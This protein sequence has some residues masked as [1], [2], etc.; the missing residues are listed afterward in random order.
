MRAYWASDEW[1][2][3]E[4]ENGNEGYWAYEDETARQSQAWDE[5]QEDYY[6]EYGYFQGKGKKGNKEEGKGKKGH[7]PQQD[8]GKGQ[9]DG[10][11]EANYVNPSHSSQSSTEQAAL[12]SLSDASGF[13]ATD[14]SMNLTSVKMIEGEDKQKGPESSGCA[15]LGQE[16]D[17]AMKVEE[18]GM[19]FHTENQMPPTV[20]ILDLGCACARAIG[21]RNAIN[22]FCEYVDKNDCGLWYKIEPTSS[23]LFFAN[24]QQT[25]CTEKLVIQVYD[26]A[27]NVQ[28]TEFD[29]VGEGNVPLLMSLPQMRNLGFQFELSPQQSFLNCARLGMWKYKLRMSKST[30]L[31]MDFQDIAWYMS[32]VYFKTP[33]VQSF[34]SEFGKFEYSQLSVETFAFAIDDDWE[35]DYHRKELIRHHKTYRSQLFKIEGSKYPI[36]LDDLES[37]RTTFIEMK[38]GTKKVEKDDWRAVSGPEKRLDKQWRGRTVFKI[39]NGVKLPE[40]LSTVKPSSKLHRISDPSDEVKPAYPPS[41]EKADDPKSSAASA[42]EG[43]SSG[44]GLTGPKRRLSQKTTAVAEDEAKQFANDLIRNST[45]QSRRNLKNQTSL[46]T[47]ARRVMM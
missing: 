2:G 17:S 19:A 7:G 36:P 39:K 15:L 18:E 33:E 11:G 27:W 24:S 25:K 10:K 37:T 4:T 44:S 1:Q 34:F 43:K 30:H 28:A 45:R 13:F 41:G 40:E 20:A 42:E 32:A 23:R 21:S 26:K 38:N 29:I 9:S 3:N 16:L 46:R 14:S 5:W 31:V 8:Q 6:D 35:I 12:P 47:V 22:A